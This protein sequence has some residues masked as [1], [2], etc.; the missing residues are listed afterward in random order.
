M[1]NHTRRWAEVLL[2]LCIVTLATAQETGV[3]WHPSDGLA[4]QSEELPEVH[5]TC[6]Q[7][8]WILQQENWYSNIEHPATFVFVSSMGTDTVENV[9]FR[10]RGNTSRGAPKKSYKVSFNAFDEDQSWE[11][12]KK[13]NLNGEH[14]DPSAMRARLAWECLRDAGVPVSRST[15]VKLFIN[16]SYYGLYSNT[17][18]IDGEWLEKRFDHAHGNLWK[19]TYPANLA[20]VSSNPDAYKFTPSWS[21]QRVYE[22]KTNNLQD[23]YSSLAEFIDVLNNTPMDELPCALEAIF[24]VDAYLKAAAGEILFGH[25]D[26]YIGNKNNFYLYERTT[27]GRLMYIPYDMDNTA[28]IQWFGEWTDQD[29]YSWTTE[30]DRALYTRLLDVEAYRERFTGY[31][32]WWMDTYY[33]VDWV[34]ARGTWLVELMSSAIQEDTYYP[35]SYG[36][37]AADFDNSISEAWGSHVAHSPLDYANSRIFWADVQSDPVP[38]DLHPIVQCWAEGPVLNDSL[39]IQ[40]WAPELTAAAGWTVEAE[41]ERDG[42]L[43]S[44]VLD[45]AGGSLHGYGWATTVPLDGAGD[46]FWRAV[47]TDPSGAV[48]HSPCSLTRVWSTSA[49]SPLRI[50]EVMPINDGFATDENGNAGDWVELINAGTAPFNCNGL[51]LSNRLMEPWRWPLP[52]VT[53]EPG[54]HLLLWCDDNT[55]AGPLHTNFTLS[56]SEDEVYLFT[57]EDGAWRTV[58]AIDWNDAI[59]NFS[60]GRTT[61]GAP[62]WVWFNPNSSNPPTPNSANGTTVYILD[63]TASLVLPTDCD[64]PCVIDLPQSTHS[65]LYRINGQLITESTGTSMSINGH[66]TGI[67]LLNVEAETGSS[68]HKII[69]R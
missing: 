61:D 41:V 60:L 59:G 52:S 24:D 69:L 66:P 65:S 46:V 22:L 29:I 1:I 2:V 13:M 58:D 47:A 51:Y 42:A 38:M 9:G 25:W 6:D 62:D 36:F 50:N 3:N 45:P 23:D 8:G 28:G 67:Y 44:V 30:N 53:L 10:L 43:E 63:P 4:Y 20:F 17:E 56:G 55:E 31:V 64:Q 19:C 5:V 39:R 16:G 18:H 68:T 14:N 48:Q 34:E 37:D 35:L 15:H 40:C 11:G 57:K 49:D 7:M 27:D 33:T 54:Q 12:L 32:H 21:N 26:N